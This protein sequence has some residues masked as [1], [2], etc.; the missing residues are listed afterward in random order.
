[1]TTYI[2]GGGCFWC[3]DAVYRRLKGVTGVKSGYAGGTLLDQPNY[4]QVATG[5][6]GFAEVVRVTFDEA[7]I[8]SDT[9]LDI[10][11]LIHDPTTLNRQGADEGTQYRSIML[12]KDQTQ[13]AAF[14][15]AITRAQKL[16]HSPIVTELTPLD[17]FYPAEDEHQD[18]YRKNPQAGYCS[19]VIEPK[20]VKVRNRYK[21]WFKEGE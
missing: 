14:K 6:T 4:Y 19:V 16:W 3:L 12:Y 7:I 18:Y 5:T 2:L 11:F 13:K 10:Y 21:K 8:P 9:I 15:A 1:M 17:I 20:I